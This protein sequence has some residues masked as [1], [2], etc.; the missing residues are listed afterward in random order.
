M[1]QPSPASVKEEL[2]P[3]ENGSFEIPSV[4]KEI[5]AES[6]KTLK[7]SKNLVKTQCGAKTK[8]LMKWKLHAKT[9]AKRQGSKQLAVP[10]HGLK[11]EVPKNTAG[12]GKQRRQSGK[13]G[14]GLRQQQ[15]PSITSKTSKQ[16]KQLSKLEGLS[17]DLTQ[18]TK[19]R[20][21]LTKSVRGDTIDDLQPTIDPFEFT[22]KEFDF[23]LENV[24]CIN[25]ENE[26]AEGDI[27]L[28]QLANR[29]K[30]QGHSYLKAVKIQTQNY[31]KQAVQTKIK[32]NKLP[33]KAKSKGLGTKRNAKM[34]R[35]KLVN[36]KD[37]PQK[38]GTNG[39]VRHQKV[40]A[41]GKDIPQKVGAKAKVIKR[42]LKADQDVESEGELE[43]VLKIE[44]EVV[45][46]A[47]SATEQLQN[48]REKAIKP[49]KE[50]TTASKIPQ[51]K[52]KQK[53]K[54][55]Q[56]KTDD[57]KLKTRISGTK[58]VKRKAK[59]DV[60]GDDTSPI[61]RRKTRLAKKLAKEAKKIKVNG[62]KMFKNVCW[63]LCL[64]VFFTRTYYQKHM[65]GLH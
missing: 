35:Q 64:N 49:K 44:D 51:Q 41:N 10:Y 14:Q 23:A 28:A 21:L 57:V 58:P 46:E 6:A 29:T 12:S 50:A 63:C 7:T 47:D 42:K 56:K 30:Q 54:V 52:N 26:A 37:R 45:C 60:S 32:P 9:I 59:K 17:S 33:V 39:R 8:A 18:N 1:S 20:R 43:S 27:P 40:G 16:V 34:K 5:S 55:K 61:K 25:N 19:Q 4:N 62:M 2:C 24:L 36:G 11:E 22:D 3:T 15:H 13:A 31:V 38:V 65:Q 53:I 48:K